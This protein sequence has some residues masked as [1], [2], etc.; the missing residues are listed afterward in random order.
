MSG[1]KWKTISGN[2]S[3]GILQTFCSQTVD[4]PTKQLLYPEVSLETTLM[5]ENPN[6]PYSRWE[7]EYKPRKAVSS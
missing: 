6:P 4:V 5:K 3:I 7:H 2:I 1:A